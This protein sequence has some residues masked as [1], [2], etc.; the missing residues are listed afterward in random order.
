MASILHGQSEHKVF[1]PLAGGHVI[2]VGRHLEAQIKQLSGIVESLRTSMHDGLASSLRSLQ[3][4][5]S[6]Q[7][8]EI[9]TLRSGQ[10]GLAKQ[11]EAVNLAAN[12][13][14]LRVRDLEAQQERSQL[15][16]AET[17]EAIGRANVRIEDLRV[18]AEGIRR[19][20]EAIEE[21]VNRKVEADDRQDR[22]LE[23]HDE[24]LV[25]LQGGIFA[26]GEALS[27]L[28]EA[29]RQTNDVLVR[30]A[31]RQLSLETRLEHTGKTV[32]VMDSQLAANI[33]RANETFEDH[34]VTKSKT[35]ESLEI[36]RK[37]LEQSLKLEQGVE[38]LWS[39]SS[40]IQNAFGQTKAVVKTHG[41]KLEVANREEC[42]A[43]CH[44]PAL[45]LC[46]AVVVFRPKGF[47]CVRGIP[48]FRSIP[49]F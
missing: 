34:L 40:T 28:E 46:W 25:Q 1:A 15:S 38:R 4:Q 47:H 16:Q 44:L 45:M 41:D 24:H 20:G 30:G 33:E 36:G 11:L 29:I 27:R 7:A 26:Q 22:H 37:L 13:A 19:R 35:K 12:K 23:K 14:E 5:G 49:R 6:A 2:E 43:L 3:E 31:E 21:R 18:Q 10:G 42:A 39:V 17:A 48:C 9:A 8:A 32:S